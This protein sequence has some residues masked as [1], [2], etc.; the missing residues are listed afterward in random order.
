M[1]LHDPQ[2]PENRSDRPCAR[3]GWVSGGT[4]FFAAGGYSH[5][6]TKLSLVGSCFNAAAIRRCRWC[7]NFGTLQICCPVSTPASARNGSISGAFRC[8]APNMSLENFWQPRPGKGRWRG[9][10][11]TG[12]SPVRQQPRCALPSPT[13]SEFCVFFP[14]P[15]S[16]S[17]H[18]VC[19]SAWATNGSRPRRLDSR[20]GQKDAR[21]LPG[22][23]AQ[24]PP[25]SIRPTS[26]PLLDCEKTGR[27]RGQPGGRRS[28][29]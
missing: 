8:C 29:R 12:A 28:A 7:S 27:R 23:L 20:I 6:S 3:V 19:V 17:G 25:T 13:A 10:G 14:P 5:A 4:L 1:T 22:R 24:L 9:N 11:T 16:P 2:P 21:M 26:R 18:A 15:P